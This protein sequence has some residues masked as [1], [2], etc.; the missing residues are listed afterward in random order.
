MW[1]SHCIPCI[2][3][4]YLDTIFRSILHVQFEDCLKHLKIFQRTKRSIT[5]TLCNSILGQ[6]EK[7]LYFLDFT[8]AESVDWSHASP[9]LDEQHVFLIHLLGCKD[10]WHLC[11]HYVLKWLGRVL[12]PIWNNCTCCLECNTDFYLLHFQQISL[13]IHKF[14]LYNRHCCLRELYT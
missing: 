14:W 3:M 1:W 10:C 12:F 4:V 2:G 8:S 5:W 6:R 11:V 9:S 13:V 7:K